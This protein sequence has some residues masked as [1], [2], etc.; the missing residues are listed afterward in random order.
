MQELVERG[1]GLDIGS[2]VIVA[3]VLTGAAGTR[4]S[5]HSRTFGTMTADL[6]DLHRWLCEHRCTHVAMES[7]GVYW[8][9]VYSAL[10]ESFELV[11]G[12]AQR[13]KNVPG[14]KT[15][16]KDSEWLADLL[17][18]GLI[19]SS[20]VP[21]KA[22]R[23]LRDL[24]R[25]RKR[26]V[27]ARNAEK[28]R[29]IKV[30]EQSNIKLASVA[31]DVFGASGMQ[32]LRLIAGGETDPEKLAN[33]AKGRL[34][35]KLRELAR[36]LEGRV[37]EHHRFLLRQQL[38]RLDHFDADLAELDV[39]I[40]GRLEPYRAQHKLLMQIPGVSWLVAAAVISEIGTDMNV[41]PTAQHLA[42]WAALCPG[43]WE[44]AGK[45]KNAPTRKGNV[46]L[47]TTLVQA[48]HAAAKKKNSYWRAKFQRLR[49]RRG[50]K[51]AAVAI[52]HKMIVAIWHML[53]YGHDY[54]ELGENH[55]DRIN[56]QRTARNLVRRLQSL[57]YEVKI[58]KAA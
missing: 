38:R 36:A 16:V 30:L 8:M 47:C 5:K 22:I 29:L 19:A 26:A 28:N 55:F 51:R 15:D 1:A 2:K 49:S 48:A 6:A 10:E 31:S 14:R 58:D 46:Y 42:S 35:N 12:N 25:Y 34:R 33:V 44:S 50:T 41:F 23:L 4:P 11:V 39:Y 7:T 32:M 52:A 40:D 13:I 21:P 17:R 37:E 27:E 57:G 24:L 54:A 53:K 43:N 20:F 45:R 3:C 56:T 9:P 18:H